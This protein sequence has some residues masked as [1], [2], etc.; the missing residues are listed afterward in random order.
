MHVSWTVEVGWTNR[1]VAKELKLERSTEI[2]PNNPLENVKEFRKVTAKTA[3][4]SWFLLVSI[5][6][7][8]E[9]K[10]RD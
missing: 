1:I 6:Q 8:V 9:T 4:L 2:H 3:H 5:E 10:F 7:H